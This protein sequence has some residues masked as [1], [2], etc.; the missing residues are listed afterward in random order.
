M[1]PPTPEEGGRWDPTDQTLPPKLC[2][3]LVPPTNAMG[4]D[5]EHTCTAMCVKEFSRQDSYSSTAAMVYSYIQ[6]PIGVLNILY[7]PH[8]L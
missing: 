7:I 1:N 5:S 4:I 6:G 3:A 2:S 8:V